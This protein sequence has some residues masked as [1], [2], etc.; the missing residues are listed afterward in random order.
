[1]KIAGI[2]TSDGAVENAIIKKFKTLLAKSRKLEIWTM[3][4]GVLS[5]VMNN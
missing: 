3:Y 5:D 2:E 1:M 4:R